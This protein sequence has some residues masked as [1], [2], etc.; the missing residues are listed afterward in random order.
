M[1]PRNVCT[2]N[3]LKFRFRLYGDRVVIDVEKLILKTQLKATVQDQRGKFTLNLDFK[4][5]L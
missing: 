1:Q 5:Q 2:P 4:T 3:K